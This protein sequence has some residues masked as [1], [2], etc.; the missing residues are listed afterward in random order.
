MLMDS[1]KTTHSAI[2]P[3]VSQSIVNGNSSAAPHPARNDDSEVLTRRKLAVVFSAIMLST[4][5]IALDQTILSTALPRIASD[6][7]AFS[8]QGWV[9]DS[10]ILSQTIFLLIYGKMLRIF[11]AKWVLVNGIALFEIGSLVCG[12]AQGVGQLI[13]GRT[14]SGIGA[15]AIFVAML[16]VISQATRLE[17]RPRLFG[18]FGAMFGLSSVIG[19]LLGGAFTE[20]RWVF[21]INLP[22]G[23]V[24]LA[25]VLL[26]LPA[27]PPLGSDPTKRAPR[28]LLKQVLQMDLV[29]A[30]LVSVAVTCLVLALQWGGN[31]KSWNDGAVIASFVV[32][33]VT[34]VMF[35]VWE[36]HL[37][38][39][40]LAP[41][42]IFKSRS[43]YGAVGL[44]FFIR[45]SLLLF[46]YYVPIFY[47]AARHASAVTSGIDLLPFI[48]SVTMTSFLGGQIISRVGYVWPFLLAAPIFLGI[49]SGLLYS[50]ET[51]TSEAK[52]VGYQI[53][54]GV[55]TGLGLQ[56]SLLVLQIE[57]KD[58]PR[59]IGQAMSMGSFAQFLGGTLGLGVAEPVFSSQL[60]KYLK[61]Y[62]PDAPVS[63]V[64]QSP[65][66]IYTALPQE[67]IAGVVEAYTA[68]LKIVF[69][70]GVPVA[71]L[72]L[73]SVVIIRNVR[74]ERQEKDVQVADKTSQMKEDQEA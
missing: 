47:Q 71:F 12:L 65:T 52:L 37:G 51:T 24:S 21:Y 2:D 15:A 10:F 6:F 63:I 58:E 22:I 32:S 18:L 9:S 41:L 8:L 68:S 60:S 13:A 33:G 3:H 5:L 36:K 30:V 16:Q 7:N 31:S 59:L 35:F 23:G 28:A 45:F 42:A 74:I 39:E 11:P 48:L 29:G 49:G 43:V 1:E 56:N 19:P 64:T 27:R 38:D 50:V 61:K 40:A 25:V 55:G 14:V 53:L 72:A 57:F 73:V 34:A 70:V 20:K 54:A 62:A 66:S 17:D 46:S 69:L 44:T 26:T 4:L 67:M